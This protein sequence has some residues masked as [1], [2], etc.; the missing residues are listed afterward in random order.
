MLAFRLAAMMLLALAA[1]GDNNTTDPDKDPPGTS[2]NGGGSGNGGGSSL[3]KPGEDYDPY[4]PEQYIYKSVFA[5][6]LIKINGIPADPAR[7]WMAF[8]TARCF[9]IKSPKCRQV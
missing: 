7:S 5:T 2:Q 6:A 4:D 3:E 9:P 8:G 1:C